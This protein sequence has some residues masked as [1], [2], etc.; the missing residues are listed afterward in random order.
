MSEITIVIFL[1]I[2]IIIAIGVAILVTFLTVKKT[3][4][5]E[6]P[7]DSVLTINCSDDPTPRNLAIPSTFPFNLQTNG[8]GGG[9]F[10]LIYYSVPNPNPPTDIPLSINVADTQDGPTEINPPPGTQGIQYVFTCSK[11]L[12]PLTVNT[13][14]PVTIDPYVPRLFVNGTLDKTMTVNLINIANISSS[15]GPIMNSSSA[16]PVPAAGYISFSAVFT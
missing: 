8:L 13:P 12:T 2:S 14:A 5:K 6:E 4:S 9:S 16:A 10:S 7:E 3:S 11:L 1:V 15:L